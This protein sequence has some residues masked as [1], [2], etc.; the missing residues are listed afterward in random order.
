MREARRDESGRLDEVAADDVVSF[1]LEAV[2][3][4]CWWISLEHTDGT[5][6]RISLSAG[7][8]RRTRINGRCDFY[9]GELS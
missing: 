4:G 5:E 3:V 7:R 2:H 8:P 9:S 6:T 1:H